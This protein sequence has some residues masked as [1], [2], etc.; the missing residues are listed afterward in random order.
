MTGYLSREITPWLE[1]TLRQLPV[2]VLSGLL[3]SGKSTLLQN[4]AL[5]P[6]L[7][8]SR[9]PR[10]P[11]VGAALFAAIPTGTTC[12][13]CWTGRESQRGKQSL[14]C[15]RI[16]RILG[17]E[18]RGRVECGP[19]RRF[20]RCSRCTRMYSSTDSQRS[21]SV[22]LD[23]APGGVPVPTAILTSWWS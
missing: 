14:Q 6:S 20:S 16:S 22:C 23:P 7:T 2:V 5:F 3:Q 15:G 8:Q 13:H 21:G 4:T 17:V 18:G 12:R 9:P 11:L 1:R 10:V 19:V